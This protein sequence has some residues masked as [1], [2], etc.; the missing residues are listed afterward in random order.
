MTRILIVGNTASIGWNLR[1]GLKKKKGIECD[2]IFKPKPIIEG[3]PTISTIDALK[4]WKYDI[5]NIHFPTSRFKFPF[6]ILSKLFRKKLV[7]IFHGSDCRNVKHIYRL[8]KW[9]VCK[10]ADK[11]FYSTTDLRKYLP[12]TAI[13]L[14]SPIDT[15]QFKPIDVKDKNVLII[16]GT[17]GKIPH[18]KMPLYLNRFKKV[19]TSIDLKLETKA[20]ISVMAL[21]ALACGCT[22]VGYEHLNRNYVINNH[23]IDIVTRKFL[24]EAEGE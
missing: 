21:E 2:I 18:N 11:I 23:S 14:P 20:F 15:E 8:L 19:Q 6:V 1:K 17:F 7:V 5:I 3:E 13:W 12:E 9:I 22:V 10:L 16:D 4:V 24:R